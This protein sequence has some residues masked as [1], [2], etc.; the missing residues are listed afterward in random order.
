VN[1][2]SAS[3]Q[4]EVRFVMQWVP[5]DQISQLAST[6]FFNNS[7]GINVPPL[8]SG[9]ATMTCN[10]SSNIKLLSAVS[11]MHRH[12]T[13]FK[14]T[15]NTGVVLYEGTEWDEPKTRDFAPPFDIAAGTRITHVC[16]YQ[17]STNTTLR[18]GSSAIT[19]EMCIFQG[20]FYP[21]TTGNVLGC[22]GF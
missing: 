17:N 9:S 5:P 15:T 18:F 12:G 1:T 22:S 10:I 21:S 14:A 19:N 11:H 6:F 20:T 4:A 16:D 3:I 8:Q 13:H 7:S 2:G